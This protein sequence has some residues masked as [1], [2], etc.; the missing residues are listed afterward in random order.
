MTSDEA[1]VL[2]RTANERWAAL[3]DSGEVQMFGEPT[4]VPAV[5]S[6]PDPAWA[7]HF[8]EVRERIKRA[9]GATAVRIEH[10]GSTAIP[11][12]AAKPV[13]DVQV[14]VPD[15]EAETT[16]REQLA[17]LG[18]PMRS[19]EPGHRY[20]RTVKGVE[21]RIQV[22][23]CKAGSQWER[24]HLLFRD[25]LRCHPDQAQAYAKLKRAFAERYGKDMLAYTAAKTPFIRSTIQAAERWASETDWC[26]A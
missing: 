22:H 15:I 12:I 20:F 9:L 17:G 7:P 10:V 5:L 2:A 19:R 6:E 11:G 4:G 1:D 8:R 25:Y 24:D 13:I 3:I 18:W 16:Y 14:S 26:V 23:V 21:P